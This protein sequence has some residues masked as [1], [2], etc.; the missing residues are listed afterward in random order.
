MRLLMMFPDDLPGTLE[1]VRA[2]PSP[3]AAAL[4]DPLA[5]VSR[6]PEELLGMLGHAPLRP[7]GVKLD[8]WAWHPLT[9]RTEQFAILDRYFGVF[10]VAA[11]APEMFGHSAAI[12]YRILTRLS[13]TSS[14]VASRR[15][16]GSR[17]ALAGL[18]HLSSPSRP[19][20]V[21]VILIA[22][23]G[24]ATRCFFRSFKPSSWACAALPPQFSRETA[25]V[26]RNRRSSRPR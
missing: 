1:S 7:D 2:V 15:P 17:V 12:A 26:R 20:T 14:A 18:A 11:G 3:I 22:A 10:R 9:R 19:A 24:R 5:R 16:Y 6:S 21:R 13:G 25:T 4:E 8:R 23:G